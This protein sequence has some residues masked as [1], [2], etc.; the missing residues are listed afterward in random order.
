MLSPARLRGGTDERWRAG[1]WDENNVAIGLERRHKPVRAPANATDGRWESQ[2]IF[3]A[4]TSVGEPRELENDQHALHA[5]PDR[6]STTMLPGHSSTSNSR[7]R[8][9]TAFSLSNCARR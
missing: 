7:A 3:C 9:Q 2:N 5:C 8:Q 4:N 6:R 1:L